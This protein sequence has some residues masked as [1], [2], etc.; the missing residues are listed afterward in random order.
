MCEFTG[1]SEEELA[2]GS[3]RSITHPEDVEQNSISFDKLLLGEIPRFQ[4]ETR[5]VRA[6]G[7]VVWGLVNVSLVRDCGGDAHYAIGQVQDMTDRKRAQEQLAY[8]ALHDPLTGL[9]NRRRLLADLEQRLAEAT[10]AQPMVLL[11]FDLDGFKAYND[12]FGHPAGDSLLIRLGRNLTGA[13]GDRGTPY[14]MGGDEFCVM[15]TLEPGAPEGIE[16]IALLSTDA[17]S[18]R[19][20]G[21]VVT[22]SYG[23]VL[24]PTEATSSADALRRADQ[25][26][27]A[28]KSLGS[29]VSP[30]RQST[31]VLLR[32]LSERSPALGIHLNRVTELCRAVAMKFAMPDDELAWLLQAASLHD[33]GKT[34]IP[35]EILNKPAPLDDE[36]WEFVRR[37]PL[38]GERILSA[39]PALAQAAKLVRSSHERFDG[40]GYP[41][42]LAGEGIPLATRIIAV[43]DAFD[44]MT[45]SRRYRTA[46]SAEGALSELRRGAGTQFDPLVVDAFRA[47]VAERAHQ[48][49]GTTGTLL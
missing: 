10:R 22:A 41:D 47:V 18:E 45:S 3:L 15:A 17:L 40:R 11:L 42:G 19:G 4:T 1:Y 8:Q 31:D 33:V 14:R 27:Y 24:L 39:A 16:R 29:R 35:D 49:V 7:R 6:D 30:G 44:A 21:F 43:C 32:V 13:L 12:T 46:M 37:H 28:R 34:A 25:R 5:Y 2:D 36:E 38:I 26:M 23:S 20:E 9:P 48:P